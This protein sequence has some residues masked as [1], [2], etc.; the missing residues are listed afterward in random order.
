MKNDLGYEVYNQGEYT[1]PSSHY[2]SRNPDTLNTRNYYKSF[3]ESNPQFIVEYSLYYKIVFRIFALIVERILKGGEIST[4]IGQFKLWTVER[5]KK[6]VDYISTNLERIKTGNPKAVIYRTNETYTT[7]Y[8]S[9]TINVD[10][11]KKFKYRINMLTAHAIPQF[12]QY[13][14][15]LPKKLTTKDI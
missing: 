4:P 3:I 8:L 14:I 6:A 1:P 12:S 10:N 5:R 11:L 7:I 15:D 9:K 2:V 13:H